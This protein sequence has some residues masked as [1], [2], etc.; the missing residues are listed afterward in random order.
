VS[1]ERVI[2]TPYLTGGKPWPGEHFA[3]QRLSLWPGS[4]YLTCGRV[5]GSCRSS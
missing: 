2:L 3:N 5:T 1:S 4:R